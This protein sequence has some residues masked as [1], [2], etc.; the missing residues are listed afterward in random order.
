MGMR[1]YSIVNG[2]LV[3][4]HRTCIVHCSSTLYIVHC[5]IVHCIVYIVHCTLCMFDYSLKSVLPP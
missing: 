1:K 3:H 4:V 2:V 5:T